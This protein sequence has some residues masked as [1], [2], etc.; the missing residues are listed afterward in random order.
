MTFCKLFTPRAIIYAAV[1]TIQV[2][3]IG[4]GE[5]MKAQKIEHNVL[6]SQKDKNG[7]KK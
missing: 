3:W 7:E 6:V 1:I 5:V 4:F 2:I